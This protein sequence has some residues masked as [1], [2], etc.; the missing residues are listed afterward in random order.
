MLAMGT[1]LNLVTGFM[2][3]LLLVNG[4]TYAAMFLHFALIPYNLFL[5]I[6]LWRLRS[7]S[8]TTLVIAAIWFAVMTVL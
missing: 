5:V 3:L 2:A 8:T 7:R 4:A 6:S 1:A